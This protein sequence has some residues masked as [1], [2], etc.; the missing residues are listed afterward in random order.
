VE[1][2][3]SDL[4]DIYTIPS[5]AKSTLQKAEN[6]MGQRLEG[7]KECHLLSNSQPLHPKTLND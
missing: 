1:V 6:F 4:K 2:E 3:Y 7:M 5:K